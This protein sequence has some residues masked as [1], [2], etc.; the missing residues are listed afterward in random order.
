[1]RR[2]G[3]RLSELAGVM[4]LAPQK[5]INVD[6]SRKPPLEELFELQ[7]AIRAAEHELAGN[8]RVLVR[9]SGTQAMCR[10]MVEG[11]TEEQTELLAQRLAHTVKQLLC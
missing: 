2:S 9:Y 8:G 5:N 4:T 11:P 10:V 1:M 6:V 3:I 7:Q